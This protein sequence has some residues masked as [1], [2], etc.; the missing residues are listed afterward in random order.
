MMQSS[1]YPF[2]YL[3]QVLLRCLMSL[4]C[5]P[6]ATLSELILQGIK[7][8][9]KLTFWGQ[10]LLVNNERRGKYLAWYSGKK[11]LY[12]WE[13]EIWF[14]IFK[15]CHRNTKAEMTNGNLPISGQAANTL[16]QLSSQEESGGRKG[17]VNCLNWELMHLKR[18]SAYHCVNF[19]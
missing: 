3:T 4:W 9:L 13:E 14:A 19:K 15:I 5:T 11:P 17:I 6:L 10:L 12:Y 7:N 1:I 16:F 18:F 8:D 2:K